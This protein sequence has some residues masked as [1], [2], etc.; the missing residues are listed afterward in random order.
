M[1]SSLQPTSANKPR[2]SCPRKP[3]CLVAAALLATLRPQSPVQRTGKRRGLHSQ[4]WRV[5]EKEGKAVAAFAARRNLVVAHHAPAATR[6]PQE[7]PD[8]NPGQALQTT[9]PQPKRR[10][11]ARQCVLG[12]HPDLYGLSRA[13]HSLN[14][15]T[16]PDRPANCCSSICRSTTSSRH[17]ARVEGTGDRFEDASVPLFSQTSAF[18]SR[19][20]F[21]LPA[22]CTCRPTS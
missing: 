17:P 13:Q 18:A 4:P 8:A 12:G 15:M 7:P 20:R 19:V 14:S 16:L 3:Y 2:D 10:R 22:R 1:S 9:P 11:R 5:K 6:L 21:R